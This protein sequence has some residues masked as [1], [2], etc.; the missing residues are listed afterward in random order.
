MSPGRGG[1]NCQHPRNGIVG[2]HSDPSAQG[3]NQSLEPSWR[4]ACKHARD[5]HQSKSCPDAVVWRRDAGLDPN[6]RGIKSLGSPIG[7]NEFVRTQLH[8]TVTEHGNEGS[9]ECLALLLFLLLEPIFHLRMVR[10]RL[11]ED[12]QAHD[13]AVW[14]CFCQLVGIASTRKKGSSSPNGI[15]QC[16]S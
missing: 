12:V 7:T 16:R 4:G 3:Q 2:T 6:Q 8:A 5:H 14:R 15:K 10:P 9:S 11:S 13:D 1:N